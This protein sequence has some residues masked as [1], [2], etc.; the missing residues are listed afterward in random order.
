MAAASAG[1]ANGDPRG[2][3]TSLRRMIALAPAE[4]DG[5]AFLAVAMDA[6]RSG[7]P[8]PWLLRT[9][10][11]EPDEPI[12]ATNLILAFR[13]AGDGR[14]GMRHA[15]R[16]LACSPAS[17]SLWLHLGEFGLTDDPEAALAPLR[18]AIAVEPDDV[19]IHLS[20]AECHGR[21]GDATARQRTLK[22]L[23][24][25]SPQLAPGHFAF[26]LSR[27][28][29]TEKDGSVR[30]GLAIDP[31]DSRGWHL[32]AERA[33]R[34]GRNDRA[35]Q[36]ASILLTLQ[37]DDLNAHTMLGSMAF[38]A[39]EPAATRFARACAIAPTSGEAL[40]N[41][42]NA[43]FR[44]VRI[45][46][47]LQKFRQAL[48]FEPG[49][50]GALNNLGSALHHLPNLDAAR[51]WLTRAMTRPEMT[52][53]AQ[54]NRAL[55][56]MLSGRLA[57]GWRD[58]E[59]RWSVPTSDVASRH[60]AAPRWE[61]ETLAGRRILLHAEQGLGDTI[62]FIRFIPAVAALGGE[63]IFESQR[64]LVPLLTG[65][66][67][68]SKI[69][70]RGDPL[71]HFDCHTSLMSLP[72]L[73]GTF[74]DPA[75]GTPY[76]A[77]PSRPLPDIIQ[78]PKAGRRIGLVWSGNPQHRDNGKR[79][80]PVEE[81]VRLAEGLLGRADVSLFSLHIGPRSEELRDRVRFERVHD[82][83]PGLQDFV[84]T[85]A[86]VSTL[87]LVITVDTVAGHL[88]GALGRPTW[89]LLHH[90]PDWRWRLDRNDSP[91]YRT[92]RLFRQERAGDWSAVIDNVLAELP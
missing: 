18:R 69:V 56:N 65:F 71:P 92:V 32:D 15:R 48:A 34:S 55:V 91:W 62:Q 52:S 72:W 6:A 16:T 38:K 50:P 4:A 87:D 82:L 19:A 49:L 14:S 90:I 36:A 1:M 9:T 23:L 30:R 3:M 25:M 88:S 77:R 68:V 39:G 75:S 44:D 13:R 29:D 35:R 47:A 27:T 12:F 11:I 17:A 80:L 45:T 42:A 33:F 24:A 46:T 51:T 86:V 73:L 37:P 81:L 8:L 22:G 66:P 2:A 83:P 67:G 70:A 40:S 89:I 7:T 63:V 59:A 54:W 61:G 78:W 53:E 79:S 76:L 74:E 21:V 26:A 10:T 84:G 64:A 85:A 31:L 43:L 5:T 57:E 60:Y 41:L 58:F 20:L 28:D